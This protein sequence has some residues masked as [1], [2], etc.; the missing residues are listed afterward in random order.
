M[1][2]AEC[3]PILS[4]FIH[5]GEKFL[6]L[7][8]AG[9]YKPYGEATGTKPNMANNTP[10]SMVH[11]KINKQTSVDAVAQQVVNYAFYLH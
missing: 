8:S 5:V 11:Q 10:T 2:H 3:E 7:V 6:I 1:R 9:V 4:T